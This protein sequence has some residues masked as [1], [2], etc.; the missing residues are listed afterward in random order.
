MASKLSETLEKATCSPI[1]VLMP[2][3]HTD[4][5]F[6]VNGANG[7]NSHDSLASGQVQDANKEDEDSDEDNNDAAHARGDEVDGGTA[8]PCGDLSIR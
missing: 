1:H 3:C 5:Y 8:I 4:L 6:T 2:P 7:A